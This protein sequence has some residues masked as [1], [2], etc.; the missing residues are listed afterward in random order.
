MEG[1]TLPTI[2]SYMRDILKALVF[3]HSKNIMHRDI[4]PSNIL[5]CATNDG[6]IPKC[7]LMDFGLAERYSPEQTYKH[8]VGTKCYKSPEILLKRRVYTPKIDIWSLGVVLSEM[9]YQVKPLFPYLPDELA[10]IKQVFKRCGPSYEHMS[11]EEQELVGKIK[12][13]KT[14][15]KPMCPKGALLAE[16]MMLFSA[17]MR[18]TAQ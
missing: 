15:K 12:P 7:R 10:N 18:P 4:K 11:V 3:I 13:E 1:I 16:K 17:D 2:K 8:G 9:L 6:S 14:N 5:V